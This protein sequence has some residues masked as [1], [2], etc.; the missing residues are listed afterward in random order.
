MPATI[1]RFEPVDIPA[2]RALWQAAEGVGLSA[3]DEA[4]PLA[5]FLTRNPGLSQVAEAAGRLAGTILVGHDGR[6]GYVHHLVV[7]QSHRRRLLGRAGGR[8]AGGTGAV[9]DHAVRLGVRGE[10]RG[11]RLPLYG[12]I[13]GRH[14]A[15]MIEA[16]AYL[17]VRRRR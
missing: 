4:A 6:R 17:P 15:I 13:G 12:R 5:A 1:R 7:A 8:A 16:H 10:A 3:A 11:A 9:V 2:A 14:A